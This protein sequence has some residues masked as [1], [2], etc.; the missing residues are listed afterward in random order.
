MR[1]KKQVVDGTKFGYKV[2]GG[3]DLQQQYIKKLVRT[4]SKK[5]LSSS[6]EFDHSKTL[7]WLYVSI[8]F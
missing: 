7:F 1:L 4:H 2:F 3:V 8:Q 5:C 6:I